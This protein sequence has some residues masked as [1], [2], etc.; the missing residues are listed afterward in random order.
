M[1]K[2]GLLC[3][4]LL[5]PALA[6]AELLVGL[7]YTN[8]VVGPNLEWANERYS[9]Y[10][11]PGAHLRKGG[12]DTD[13]LRWVVGARRPLE[14]TTM[15][16]PGFFVGAMFGDLG[17]RSYERLGLGAEL[18]RQWLTPSVRFTVSAGI[19]VLQEKSAYDK[20]MEPTLVLSTTFSMRR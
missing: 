3:A 13:E 7:G 8:G 6:S 17:E 4:A 18:G 14:R 2:R 15:Q 11:L 20:D 16:M 10:V 19:A 9:L 1:I 5:C 12:L